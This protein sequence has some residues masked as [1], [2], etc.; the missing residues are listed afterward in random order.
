MWMQDLL[1]PASGHSPPIAKGSYPAS[2]CWTHRCS[3][4]LVKS[5]A[6]GS[7]VV[8]DCVDKQTR[9][10]ELCSETTLHQAQHQG[11]TFVGS[12]VGREMPGAVSLPHCKLIMCSGPITKYPRRSEDSQAGMAIQRGDRN[13]T[14]KDGEVVKRQRGRESMARG[15]LG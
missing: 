8:L 9:A 12:Y 11:P 13:W 1:A 4:M 10:Q 14:Q 5:Q 2:P 15:W 6:L 7:R 3:P